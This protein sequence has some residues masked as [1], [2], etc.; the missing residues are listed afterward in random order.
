MLLGCRMALRP[1]KVK[2][3]YQANAARR[4]ADRAR[5]RA[6]PAAATPVLP[7]KSARRGKRGVRL[8]P[9]P[10][11]KTVCKALRASRIASDRAAAL[12][13]A[14]PGSSQTASTGF[15]PG[16]AAAADWEDVNDA[17][18]TVV[19]LNIDGQSQQLQGALGEHLRSISGIDGSGR[20]GI[21]MLQDLGLSEADLLRRWDLHWW[22]YGKRQDV[23]LVWAYA[24]D[25]G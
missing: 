7:A 12:T 6:G 13:T 24:P 11:E 2:G 17:K 14:A 16:G 9:T 19:S 3:T 15:L 4:I 5:R 18:W 21:V 23:N 10:A 8:R 22:K 20:G 1:P 25:A